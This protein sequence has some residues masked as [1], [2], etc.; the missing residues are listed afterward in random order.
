MAGVRR[1]HCER[2]AVRPQTVELR[3][4]GRRLSRR[5]GA[6]RE[7][8]RVV[9]LHGAI[10]RRSAKRPHVHVGLDESYAGLED[11]MP[12]RIRQEVVGRVVR[13]RQ[14]GQL[15]SE[16]VIEEPGE[17]TSIAGVVHVQLVEEQQSAVAGH[18]VDRSLYRVP[19]APVI[20]DVARAARRR[21]RGSGP[22]SFAGSA[23]PCRTHQLAKT[24]PAR[25]HRGCRGFAVILVGECRRPA[26]D[27]ARRDDP[28]STSEPDRVRTRQQM[29]PPRRRERTRRF[30]S[31]FQRGMPALVGFRSWSRP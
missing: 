1:G 3:W 4:R 19:L 11:V 7:A 24:C 18:V 2:A 10:V 30:L 17:E 12:N 22:A 20:V 6:R 23:A 21:T 14:D 16:H 29:P 26:R 28:A 25:R 5:P 9:V 8:S 15:P 27:R 13:G 31:R